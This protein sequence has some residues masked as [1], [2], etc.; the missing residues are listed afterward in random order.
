MEKA[1]LKHCACSQKLMVSWLGEG[2]VEGLGEW[3]GEKTGEKP[4]EG[5]PGDPKLAMSRD[6]IDPRD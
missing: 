3:P 1:T 5:P 2:L 6:D 4:D